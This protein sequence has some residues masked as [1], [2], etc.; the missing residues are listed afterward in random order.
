MIY[1]AK[2]YGTK[3]IQVFSFSLLYVISIL[4]YFANEQL[5]KFKSYS[6]E[7]QFK[8]FSNSTLTLT[9]ELSRLK[10]TLD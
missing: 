3:Q 9:S 1:F 5:L 8:Y 10:L 7:K 6:Q 4:N 2:N